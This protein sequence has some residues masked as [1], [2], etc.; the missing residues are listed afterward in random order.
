MLVLEL[1]G[2]GHQAMLV[3]AM[4]VAVVVVMPSAPTPSGIFATSPQGSP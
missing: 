1:D 4:V 3:L 2:N